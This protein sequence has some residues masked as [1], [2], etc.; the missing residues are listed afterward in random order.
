MS[1]AEKKRYACSCGRTF[2]NEQILKYHER[3]S[4]HGQSEASTTAAEPAV[5]AAVAPTNPMAVAAIETPKPEEAPV[6]TATQQPDPEEDNPLA[7]LASAVAVA[8]RNN[9]PVA[10]A[11]RSL[12]MRM[13]ASSLVQASS[14]GEADAVEGSSENL[15]T[16][17]IK[18]TPDVSTPALQGTP[19]ERAENAYLAAIE[20]LRCK[21]AEQETLDRE[22]ADHLVVDQF[23]DFAGEVALEAARVGQR[24]VSSGLSTAFQILTKV[25]ILLIVVLLTASMFTAGVGLVTLVADCSSVPAGPA[26][27]AWTTVAGI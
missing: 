14:A 25:M 13:Q 7:G 22:A 17:T 6:C 15:V 24:A 12:A 11:R 18:G 10:Q 9:A 8:A 21:R 3:V 1:A 5:P 27:A 26:H 20:I 23:V 2:A 19:E 16:H 4:N